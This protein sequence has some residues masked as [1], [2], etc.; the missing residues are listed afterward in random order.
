VKEQKIKRALDLAVSALCLP[1]IML[2]IFLLSSTVFLESGLPVIFSQKRLGR[3]GRVFTMYKIRSM[4]QNSEVKIR[5]DGTTT[6]RKNDTRTTK[7]GRFIR[8]F[9]LDELPQLWNIFLGEMSLVG[10]RPDE[11]FSLKNYSNSDRKKL[12]VRPGVFGLPQILGGS[13]IPWKKRIALDIGYIKNWSL[14]LDIA[15]FAQSIIMYSKI[16]KFKKIK[17]LN[18]YKLEK[19]ALNK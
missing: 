7:V 4:K 2:V 10:P 13:S 5:K 11:P 18:F 19:E 1:I 17:L 6:V 9:N 15:I 12:S 14:K 16:P 8:R 3:W